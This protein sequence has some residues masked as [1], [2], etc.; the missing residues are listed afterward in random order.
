[1]KKILI[2]ML[3]LSA[4]ILCASTCEKMQPGDYHDYLGNK[5]NLLGSWSLSGIQLQTAGVIEYRE[6]TPE[7]VMEFAAEG[8]GYTK[9][10]S[11]ELLASWRYETY[12]G[13]VTIFTLEEWE[14]NRG[15]GEDDSQY[16]E[17]KT[18]HFHVVDENT[19]SYEEKISSN[20]SVVY[21]YTR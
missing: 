14:N 18:Y 13:A 7:S 8:F 9:D 19:I 15:L 1:M 4:M 3:A 16:E 17:G 10:L 21:F 12:R 2:G 6:H 20:T 5:I 11:G